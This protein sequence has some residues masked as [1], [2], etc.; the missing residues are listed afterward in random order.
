M[1][2]C[3]DAATLTLTASA[4]QSRMLTKLSQAISL[5][6]VG[7][8]YKNCSAT[9][10]PANAGIFLGAS[11]K[12][13][14]RAPAAY[15]YLQF[16]PETLTEILEYILRDPGESERYQL[17]QENFKQIFNGDSTEMDILAA[18]R[19]AK[20]VYAYGNCMAGGKNGYERRGMPCPDKDIL[21]S[22]W[23]KLS[24]ADQNNFITR[25][26]LGSSHWSFL[27]KWAMGELVSGA[28]YVKNTTKKEELD[29]IAWMAWKTVP[30]AETWF[31]NIVSDNSPG[32]R[33]DILAI[34]YLQ[35]RESQILLD[36][37]HGLKYT[38]E[39]LYPLA[40]G[41]TST[42]QS[43]INRE[44]AMRLARRHNGGAW[45]LSV[46]SLKA[47]DQNNYVKKIIGSATF[48]NYGNYPSLRCMGKTDFS[49]NG[50]LMLSLDLG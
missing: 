33:I 36:D 46:D 23:D 8:I 20:W 44:M 15:S 30:S 28:D 7:Q 18:S 21:S 26:G 34:T 17:S 40:S 47:R 13:S 38:G 3:G 5:N 39:I 50:M 41:K 31:N 16:A 11:N 27:K 25:T 49:K 2:N 9:G 12:F 22:P 19:R 37:N 4:L 35:V 6:E 48:E 32:G 24:S 10:C 42:E 1:I 14:D 45:W 43:A 29:A